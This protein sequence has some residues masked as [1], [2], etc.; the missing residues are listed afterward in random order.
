MLTPLISVIVP[1]YHREEPLRHTL[2]SLLAQTYP[3]VEILVVDQTIAHD[4]DTTELLQ[5]LS[6]KGLIE[7]HRVE[8]ANLPA[9][10]NYGVRRSMG[11]IL[12]FI[13]DDVELPP[14]FLWAHVHN[15]QHPE[16]AGVAGRVLPP[17]HTDQPLVRPQLH[18]PPEAQDPAIAWFYLDFSNTLQAQAVLTARGCN[19][20]FRRELFFQWNL[21]FDE[22]FG[23]CAVREESDFCLRVRRTGMQIWYDP[24]AKLTHFGEQTGGCHTLDVRSP[25]YQITFYHNHFWMALKNLTV[26]QQ[27]RFALRLFDCHVLGHA[28]CDKERSPIKIVGRAVF[29]LLGL[30]QAG[31]TALQSRWSDGQGYSQPDADSCRKPY[32]HR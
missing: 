9:A 26:V 4:P 2:D 24:T 25:Q 6:D 21:W 16:T 18:L 23:G 17:A 29:Y 14:H 27:V 5:T 7:W 31:R 30:L 28:P 3:D 32:L 13:D 15:Y 12:V 19:M 8:W 11:S 22:R 10:R 1:T 20:S